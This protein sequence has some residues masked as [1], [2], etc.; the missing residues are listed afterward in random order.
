[1]RFKENTFGKRR[2]KNVSKNKKVKSLPRFTRNTKDFSFMRGASLNK[3]KEP[4][5]H[6]LVVNIIQGESSVK[7][8]AGNLMQVYSPNHAAAA[9]KDLNLINS[10]SELKWFPLRKINLIK[11]DLS[12]FYLILSPRARH[13]ISELMI[14]ME[15]L[16]GIK[17]CPWDRKQT[18]MSLRPYLIEEAYEVIAAIESEDWDS[19][20]EELGD[21]L[22][23]V[24]FHAHLG[25]EE[26]HFN[27]SGVVCEV[28]EKLIRRHP[29]VFGDGKAVSVGEVKKR[30]E[31]IKKSE[32]KKESREEYKGI[33]QVDAF[34]PALMRAF[35]V[36]SKAS[37]VGFDWNSHRGPLNKIKEEMAEIEAAYREGSKKKT[38]EELGDLLFSVVNLSRF[39]GVNPEIAL[40]G[41]TKKFIQRFSYIEE[42]AAREKREISSYTLE[43]LDIWWDEAKKQ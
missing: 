16:R 1:M 41:A 37:G 30:W 15:R 36:Q 20:R 11:R 26:G 6:Y 14:V 28:I 29:H 12:S 23:Q 32:K 40:A 4:L 43:E 38:E 42:M 34:L 8:V 25:H 39:I 35:K 22:L 2:V 24:I 9:V 17:G 31:E 13:N 7:E 18:H 21:L 19:L 33:L 27:F 10:L 5:S 3:L